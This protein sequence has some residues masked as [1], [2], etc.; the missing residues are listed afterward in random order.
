MADTMRVPELGEGVDHA[1][2]VSVLVSAGDTVEKDQ[3]VIEVETDKA[4]VEVPSTVAGTVSE[5]HVAEGDQLSVGDP[6]I[7]VD[8]GEGAVEDEPEA[9]EPETAEPQPEE[10]RADEKAGD[11]AGEEVGEDTGEAADEE[12]GEKAGQGGEDRISEEPSKEASAAEPPP[13]ET[14]RAEGGTADM[15]VPDLGEGVDSVEV[16]RVLVSAGDTVEKDQPVIEVE[17]DKAAVEVPATAAGEVVEV[18]AKEGAKLTTG[19]TIL[20]LRTDAGEPEEAEAPAE[21]PEQPQ[22]AEGPGETEASS[23]AEPAERAEPQDAARAPREEKK[24]S[25]TER[26][27]EELAPHWKGRPDPKRLVPAAPSVRRFAREVGI[28]IS[29]VRGSGPGGR[30]SI[31]D[32]KHHAHR[33]LSAEDG[34]VG[35]LRPAPLP[36]FSVWGEVRSEPMSKVRQITAESMTRAHLTVPQVTH[37]DEADITRLEELR[38]KF[39]PRVEKVGGKLTVTAILVRVAASA[40]RVFPKLNASVDPAEKRVIFKDHVHVGVAVDTDRGLLVPV[41]R[42]ADRKNIAAIAAELGDLAERARARKLKLD[43][44]QGASFTISNLGGIGGTSFTPIVYWPQVAILGVS[45]GVTKPVWNGESFEPR[46]MLPLSLSYDHRLV[47]GADAA[48]FLRWLAEALEQP[49][50]LALEG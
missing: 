27:D 9:A 49:L 2:V 14:R 22:K 8:G 38:T 24:P 1:D 13:P 10:E 6:I 30:L 23:E 4:A 16:V 34:G 39:K 5:V 28:D 44:M 42:D 40:L 43:E 7:T 46:L 36:D 26:G 50:L 3:P 19:D 12:P 31:D 37:H 41:V 25:P 29:Q 11:D 33:L 20:T 47:D 32:V 17:T 45:R 18:H 48:R 35:G 21:A 15:T